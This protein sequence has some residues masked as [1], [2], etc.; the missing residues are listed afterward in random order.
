MSLRGN[1]AFDS[2]ALM[3]YEAG[4]RWQARK[5]LSM[6]V[7]VFYNN[8]DNIYTTSPNTNLNN[9][10][11]FFV[12]GKQG[13]GHGVEAA[14]NWKT[15]SWLSLFFTYTWQEMELHWKDLLVIHTGSLGQDFA[16][17]TTPR[18]Q[19]AIRSA[20][21]FAEHWQFNSWLRYVDAIKGRNVAD[22]APLVPID[23]YFLL[24]ANL[25]WKPRKGL[26]VMLA[27]QNLLNSSQLQYTSELITP[28]T[29]IDRGVYGKVT[30]NF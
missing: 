5:N 12:N 22:P 20:V 25:I 10:D 7:A 30:W 13:D 8:Y 18:H 28:P 16:T 2:E 14:V 1:S 21:D 6:D 4:Y 3:A 24:D 15:N 27:G 11:Q 26:E 29:K 9:F 19:A 17:A 23:A